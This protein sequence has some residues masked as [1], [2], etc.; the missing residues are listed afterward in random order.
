MVKK[1]Q[2]LGLVIA[3]LVGFMAYS[4]T[5][6]KPV[7]VNAA[8][9]SDSDIIMPLYNNTSSASVTFT[10]SSSGLATISLYCQGYTDVTTKITAYTYI[11]LQTGSSWVTISNGQSNNQWVDTVSGSRLVTS[12]TLQLTSSGTYKAVV[13]YNVD[14]TGGATDIIGKSSTKTYSKS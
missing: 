14:G 1:L 9:V 13:V 8:S 12:H 5:T 10:I 11:Q 6:A 2:S 3:L 4:F 7:T